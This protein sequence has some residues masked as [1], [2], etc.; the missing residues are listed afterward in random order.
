MTQKYFFYSLFIHVSHC[1]TD[2]CKMHS[3]HTAYI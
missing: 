2:R 3:I 1:L